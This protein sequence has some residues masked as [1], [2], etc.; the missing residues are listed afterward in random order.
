MNWN[1]CRHATETTETSFRWEVEQSISA[2]FEHVVSC[3]PNRIAIAA[4]DWQPTFAELNSS[5]NGMAR[6][7]ISNGV[8][9]GDRVVVLMQHG[10][11]SIAAILAILKCGGVVAVL[12]PADPPTRL[13]Q[14]LDDAEPRLIVTDAA[15]AKLAS[16]MAAKEIGVLGFQ[17]TDFVSAENPDVKIAPEALAFLIYTS[18]STGRP[19]GVMQ[20]HRNILHNIRRLSRGMKMTPNDKSIL[21]AFMSGAQ[22]IATTWTA[23]LNG[24]A[25]CPFPLMERSL[26]GL[27]EFLKERRI[28][29]WVSSAS[30]FR[31]F[32]KT[33]A[34]DFFPEM[35]LVRLGSEAATSEDFLAFKRHFISGC[36]L[37][38]TLS[39]SEAGNISQLPLMHEDGVSTGRLPAGTPADGIEMALM[40]EAGNPVPTGETG[41]IWITGRYLSPG[42]WR[43]EE[44]TARQFSTAG[45]KRRTFRSGDLGRRLADGSYIHAGRKDNQVKIHG[46]RV[47]LTEIEEA[48]NQCPMVERA[49]VCARQTPAGDARL[50]AFVIAKSRQAASAENLRHGLQNQLPRHMTPSSFTFLNEFPLTPHGKINRQALLQLE[51]Q[52]PSSLSAAVGTETETA[53]AE[54]WRQVFGRE[55]SGRHD[56]FFDLG[57]D[58]LNAAVMASLIYAKFGLELNFRTLAENPELASL[59]KFIDKLGHEARATNEFPLTPVPRTAPLPLSFEEEVWLRQWFENKGI[60][61]IATIST[62]HS[63]RGPLNPDTLRECLHHLV[64]RH[65]IFRTTFD[66]IKGRPMRTIHPA[67]P[68]PLPQFDF[69]TSQNGDDDVL[70]VLRELANRPFDLRHDSPVRFALAKINNDDFRFLIVRHHIASDGGSWKIF[71]RELAILYEARSRGGTPPLP[72]LPVQYADYVVWWRKTFDPSQPAFAR[73]VQWW[74]DFILR[75]SSRE[76]WLHWRRWKQ[77]RK[78]VKLPITEIPVKRVQPCP[79]AKPSDGM[80]WWGINRETSRRLDEIGR[81]AHATAFMTRLAVFVALFSYESSSRD[82]RV[83]TPVSKRSHP[84][85][86]NVFGTFATGVLLPFQCHP[87]QTFRQWLGEVIQTVSDAQAH[88]EIHFHILQ[89]ELR[90]SGLRLGWDHP[91]FSVTDHPKVMSFAGIEMKPVIRLREQMMPGFNLAMDHAEEENGCLAAFD[92]RVFDPARM[93]LFI[94]RLTRLFSLIAQHPDSTL[95]DLLVQV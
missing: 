13:R 88:A 45:D 57:G 51:S 3:H 32:I 52:L 18:G 22:G 50:M 49:V 21:L 39:S 82:V 27:T 19:K 95:R 5:A 71:F 15:N 33:L 60:A 75:Q 1:E 66:P 31:A 24:A 86:Q 56:N 44:L 78:G 34:R 87:R 29:V 9:V 2:R 20:T 65:E 92:A 93:R 76:S 85:M 79:G 77:I 10:G 73:N 6:E 7:M 59:A 4:G 12:N 74:R 42:Y 94:T 8:I 68:V 14:V 38:H 90:K 55:I 70:Q 17:P 43:N 30:V 81:Y 54:I 84:E 26:A 83:M 72:P 67:A 89:S 11:G 61:D 47:E 28:T 63:L 16:E 37:L 69:S 25:I 53:L 91:V 46:H 48:L 80:I 40:D 64:Q 62:C 35:R 36:V 23:L 41:E 58:S